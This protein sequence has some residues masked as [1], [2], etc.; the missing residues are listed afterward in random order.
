MSD[1]EQSHGGLSSFFGARQ[2][3]RHERKRNNGH[4]RSVTTPVK[5]SHDPYFYSSNI[6]DSNR[7]LLNEAK[8]MHSL[9]DR[10]AA[11]DVEQIS[12]LSVKLVQSIERQ[13]LLEDLI[14]Q[15]RFEN[16]RLKTQL[17]EKSRFVE[18][19]EEKI[20]CGEL[21]LKSEIDMESR[22]LMEKLMDESKQRM[23]AEEDREAIQG[24]L[25]DLSRNLFEEANRMVSVAR[26]ELE[27]Q[28]RRNEQL[29]RQ[30]VDGKTLL[31]SQQEQLK[32][33]KQVMQNMESE[34]ERDK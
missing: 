6:D 29:E 33:L 17:E 34:L 13:A 14:S 10:D 11:T 4:V 5:G 20:R 27:E 30:V 8:D 3:S 9:D 19:T 22:N 25:E 21:M 24:E 26:R 16:T 32:E 1:S 18:E 28:K 31:S 2:Q 12:T 23:Q 7:D 15:C